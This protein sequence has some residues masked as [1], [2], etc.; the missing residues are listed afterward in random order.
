MI[1]ITQEK[2]MGGITKNYVTLAF[3]LSIDNLFSGILPADIKN[4]VKVV[5]KLG[6]LKMG[7]DYNTLSK[8]KKRLSA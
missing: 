6:I 2:R 1:S 3:V 8:I 5:N 7:K 4:N